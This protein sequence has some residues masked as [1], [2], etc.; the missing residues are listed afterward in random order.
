M[1]GSVCKHEINRVINTTASLLLD[2]PIF[3]YPVI[4][5]ISPIPNCQYPVIQFISAAA[6]IV[7]DTAGVELKLV[8]R[9]INRNTT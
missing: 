7:V 8:A 4:D 6:L 9:C 2:L 5:S 1:Y 3:D